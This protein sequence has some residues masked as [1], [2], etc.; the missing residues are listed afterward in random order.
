[1]IKKKDKNSKITENYNN[2]E[3]DSDSGD[4]LNYIKINHKNKIEEE[5]SEEHIQQLIF[6]SNALTVENENNIGKEMNKFF[7][8]ILNENKEGEALKVNI[9]I[10]N[11]LYRDKNI[12]NII[13]LILNEKETTYIVLN[14]SRRYNE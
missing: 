14:E 3:N 13:N 2:D 8:L 10:S 4:Y 12:N 5:G 9:A 7:N 1:M 6:F 11:R